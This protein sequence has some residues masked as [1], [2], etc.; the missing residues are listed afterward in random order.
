MN[1]CA[2]VILSDNPLFNVNDH[3]FERGWKRKSR[4]A[5]LME[6]SLNRLSYIPC[7]SVFERYLDFGIGSVFDVIRNISQT[8]SVTNHELDEGY[9]Q[10]IPGKNIF[11]LI[12]RWCLI[13]N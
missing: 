5:H 11:L 13:A 4:S 8:L 9:I 6:N 1:V 10:W 7:A 12:N 3:I 2:I